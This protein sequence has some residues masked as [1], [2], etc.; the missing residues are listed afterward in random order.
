MNKIALPFPVLKGSLLVL[1]AAVLLL[2]SLVSLPKVGFIVATILLLLGWV[3]TFYVEGIYELADIPILFLVLGTFA[4]GRAFSL[5][6]IPLG[7]VPLYV[8]EMM[9]GGSLGLLLLERKSLKK[10]WDE[11]RLPLPRGLT[12]VLVAYFLMGTLYLFIGV[13]GNGILALRD[14]VFCHYLPF[15]FITLSLLIKQAK[16]KSVIPFLIPGIIIVLYTGLTLFFIYHSSYPYK[17]P[18]K[19]FL[20]TA[21]MFNLSLYFGLIVIFGLS[22]F[23]FVKRKIKPVIG[24][25]IHLSLLFVIMTEIRAS[26]VGMIVA[27][28]FL[29]ILLKKEIKILL[30]ILLLMAGSLFIIDYFQLAINKEKLADLKEEIM[31]IAQSNL[32]SMRAAN[33][34]WRLSIWKQT[35]DEIRKSPILGWGYG[36]QIDY[37]IWNK[38]LSVLKAIGAST[39]ILPAHNH[40]LAVIYKMGLVGLAL[41]LFFNFRIFFCGLSYLKK[42]KS[43]FN[44]RF[45]IACLAS[46][47]YWHG[48]AFFFDLL[49][50]PTTGIFL[51][52]LLGAVLGVIY[53]DR[54]SENSAAKNVK[55]CE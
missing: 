55:G 3:I 31:S 35:I 50:S 14:I 4:Y 52:I 33:I 10:L 27:W 26:W 39:G 13:I 23:A 7:N 25:L 19:G 20:R 11:W 22:F 54:N 40:V 38:R 15:L 34:K 18:Y 44:R 32:E 29:T 42:C 48:M 8:T 45:L 9:L 30:L 24:V 12:I 53:V 21:K 36:T 17:Y 2:F 41:F 1:L 49:E 37:M 47:V 46:L 28:I 43:A 51:W 16:I 5:I 6:G